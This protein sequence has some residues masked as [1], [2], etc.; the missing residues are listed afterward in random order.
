VNPI[1]WK[2]FFR[3]LSGGQPTD[4]TGYLG[5]QARLVDEVGEGVTCVYVGDELLLQAALVGQPL[6]VPGSLGQV[7]EHPLRPVRAPRTTSTLGLAGR[8][9]WPPVH[10][11]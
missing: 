1:D 10:M 5:Y 6:V 9:S 8:R 7:G 4:S 3:A 2:T 11:L